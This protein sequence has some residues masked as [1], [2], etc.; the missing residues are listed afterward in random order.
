M[1]KFVIFI[2]TAFLAFNQG[3]CF[4]EGNKVRVKDVTHIDGIRENQLVGYGIVVGLPGTGDNSVSTQ[5]SSMAM[6]KNLGTVIDNANDIKKGNTAAVIIT[7]MV[8]PFV[9][10]GDK[11]DVTV[12]SL[13]DAASLEGGVLIQTQLVAPN[14]EVVAVAQG[15]VSVGGVSAGALGSNSNTNN[16]M[17]RTSITT[18]GRIPNGAIIE[19]DISTNIGDE[20][21]LKLVLNK[22]DFTMAA[23]LAEVVSGSIASAKAIDAGTVSVIIP[24]RFNDDRI[25]FISLLENLTINSADSVA[26]IVVN[27]RT[28]TIVIGS[29]VKLLPAAVAHGNLTVTITTTNEVSQPNEMAS[30]GQTQKNSNTQIKINKERGSLIEVPANANLSELVRALNSI[31]VTPV[32][33]ISILQ[34]LKAA[35]SLQAT[36]EII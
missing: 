18:S 2:T 9:R 22:P 36:L 28:G 33:L 35:G 4:A 20:T 6:L 23:K 25:K 34:A 7:A 29:E 8:P 26:K 31:G 3:G 10:N 17:A 13:A 30:V 14:G 11:I 1:K 24:Q 12:S 21:G 19:R 15:P 27:E 32:D 5:I 16:T